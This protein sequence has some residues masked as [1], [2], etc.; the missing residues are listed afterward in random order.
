MSSVVK[1][2]IEMKSPSEAD[3]QRFLGLAIAEAITGAKAG[4]GGPF[5]A[6][7]VK[8][9]QVIAK[10]SN[11]VVATND[12]TAHAEVQ[13]IRAACSALGSF[14]LDGCDIYASCEPCPMCLGAILW[15]RPRA[16]YYTATRVQAAQAG[17]DDAV[18]YQAL[19][20]DSTVSLVRER[21]DHTDASSPFAAY[22]KL[23]G[24]VRY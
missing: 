20:G 14:Q 7:V 2:A 17:F 12:P 10:A 22:A 19:E 18:F 16:L 15:A 8:D 23:P 24:R 4:Q 21:V 11:A 1:S 13:A 3:K 5:G 9:G 6:V